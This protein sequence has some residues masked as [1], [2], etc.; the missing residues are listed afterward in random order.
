MDIM[1][2]LSRFQE[3]IAVILEHT[4]DATLLPQ[5]GEQVLL[6]VKSANNTCIYQVRLRCCYH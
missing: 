1:H 2:E 5:S 6:D 4:K 3:V